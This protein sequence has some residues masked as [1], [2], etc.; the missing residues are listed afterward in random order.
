MITTHYDAGNLRT[1][2]CDTVGTCPSTNLKTRRVVQHWTNPTRPRTRMH[3]PRTRMHERSRRHEHKMCRLGSSGSK[4]GLY[5][6]L[7]FD[8]YSS[9]PWHRCSD[10]PWRIHVVEVQ[11]IPRIHR[12]LYNSSKANTYYIGVISFEMRI[13]T[14][15]TGHRNHA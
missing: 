3:E 2:L 5:L 10:V 4:F 15:H 11:F 9:P 7:V 1:I 8:F 12:T 14:C 6:E 13:L